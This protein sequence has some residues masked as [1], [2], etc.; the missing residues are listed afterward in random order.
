MTETE[1]IKKAQTGDREAFS[2]LVEEWY[3][4]MFRMA[5]KW[6]GHRQDA[7]DI[8]QNACIKLARSLSSFQFKSSFST[9]LYRLVINT[10]IDLKRAR[11]EEVLAGEGG[12]IDIAAPASSGEDQLYARE[13]LAYV[14]DLPDSERTALIL[15]MA[16]GMSHKEAAEVMECKESTVSWHIHE[17]R[18]KLQAIAEKE[19]RHG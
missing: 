18:K 13:M 19:R 2:A 16:E 3:E 5:Y 15:V 14:Y 10:G 1:L 8:V 4:P 6:C 17:A 12:A 11:K 7:E 9:W